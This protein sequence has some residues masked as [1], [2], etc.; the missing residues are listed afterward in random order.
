[1]DSI[2]ERLQE[3]VDKLFRRNSAAF[4]KAVGLPPTSVANYLNPKVASKPSADKLELIIRKTGVDGTWLLTGDGQML[5][6]PVDQSIHIKQNHN[7][8]S[9][10]YGYVNTAAHEDGKKLN[11]DSFVIDG[12][13]LT[14]EQL[15]HYK[16]I[17]V[18]KDEQIARLLSMIEEK[19]KMITKLLEKI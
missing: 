12:D 18:T 1:M 9:T 3:I 2:N 13:D 15:E 7:M 17:I 10:I 16:A 8:N 19:D 6:S 4:A 11:S 14:S 5:K